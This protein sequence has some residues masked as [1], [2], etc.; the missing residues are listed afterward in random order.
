MQ[1]ER[2]GKRLRF[3]ASA[4]LHRLLG[5]DLLPDDYSA[6]EELVK[7]AYDS[8]A[9]EVTLTIVRSSGS[10]KAEIEIRD[11]GWGL[12]L[13]EFRRVWMWAG[14]SEKTA[15]PLPTTGRVQVG[16]KGIGRFAADK[17]GERKDGLA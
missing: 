12:S 1:K 14:Y 8:N 5:R 9:T 15:E 17:L 3:E 7:N 13:E 6:V 4:K 10:Q 11:N 16:E 2:Q